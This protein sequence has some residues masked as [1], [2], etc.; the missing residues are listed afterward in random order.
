MIKAVVRS[1]EL[2]QEGDTIS[3]CGSDSYQNTVGM[4][5]TSTDVY[6][7]IRIPAEHLTGRNSIEEVLLYV[8]Q[9]GVYTL[10]IHQGNQTT[11][12]TLLFSQTYSFT[13][14]L[15]QY[16]SCTLPY[17][18]NIDT[19]QDLWVTF[20]NI[21]ISY[22]AAGC[23]YIGSIRSDLV[24]TDGVTWNHAFSDY[25]LAYTWMIKVVTSGLESNCG[26]VTSF[27]YT[28]DFE[29][30]DSSCW[31]FVNGNCTNQWTIG[32]ATDNSASG[33]G[34]ALYISNNGGTSN[35]YDIST[36]STALVYR[37]LQLEARDY[38]VSFDWK[39]NGETDYDY[40][41]AALIPAS[42]ALSTNDTWG[43]AS[44]PTGYIPLDNNAQLSGQSMWNTRSVNVSISSPGYYNL[45]FFWHNDNNTGSNP[46]AA[47][48]NILIDT[49]WGCDVVTTY[50]TLVLG[51]CNLPYQ[52]NG[53]EINGAGDYSATLMTSLGCD[54]IVMLHLT[55]IYSNTGDTTAVACDS[56]EWYGVTLTETGDYTH[57]L[58]NVMD[59]DSVVT[60]HLTII[61]G[62]N[63]HDFASS[64]TIYPN[65]TNG[66]VN[67]QC[68]MNTIQAGTVE[69]HVF[70]AFGR[71]L[72]STNA[73]GSSVQTQIDLSHFASGVYLIK[74]VA[75]GNVVAVRK[76]IKN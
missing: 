18:I 15:N 70:D 39:A 53:N 56:F 28:M 76:V 65:P 61:V 33:S 57:T 12:Q 23:E 49:V 64:M 21:G 31:R 2:V 54:S 38:I 7:G 58:T 6:W 1:T 44:L 66:M 51:Y 46:P 19:T 24:S 36:A 72:Q 62:I 16:R 22:P 74:A 68:T 60:L 63:D 59:C 30:D 27:P 13:S 43:Y 52:W 11:P 3:Y 55:V 69:F 26:V 34:H 4:G 45:V 50:D 67:V 32:T 10:S 14:M 48:D 17:P 47:I 40:L 35:F 75:D 42:V 20:H 5:S 25:N 9:A 29:T 8:K 71:F 41:R 73:N 37:T